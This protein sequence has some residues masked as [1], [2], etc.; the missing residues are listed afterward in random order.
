MEV[1]LARYDLDSDSEKDAE[2][3][4]FV[5]SMMNPAWSVKNSNP[6]TQKHSENLKG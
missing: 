1:A 2:M 6:P 4:D 5:D 3:D